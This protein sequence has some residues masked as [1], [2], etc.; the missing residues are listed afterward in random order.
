LF[1]TSLTFNHETRALTR[2]QIKR[3]CRKQSV[4]VKSPPFSLAQ[5]INRIAAELF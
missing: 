5:L 1:V 3:T 4:V 2:E